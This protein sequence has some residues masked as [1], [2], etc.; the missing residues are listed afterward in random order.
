MSVPK[1]QPRQRRDRT[2]QATRTRL[3][4]AAE[5]VFRRDGYHGAELREIARRASVTTGAVYWS[6]AN[7]ADLFLA[8]FD[9][10]LE[11]RIDEITAGAIEPGPTRRAARN[12]ADW[13]QRLERQR[14]W[15]IVLLEFRL[16]AARHP[17]LNREFRRRHRRLL[18]ASARTATANPKRE[19][20]KRAR[21]SAVGFMALGN[22]F[23]L[24][25]LTDPY[26]VTHEQYVDA[27]R[28]MSGGATRRPR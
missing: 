19:P 4:D 27:A 2:E 6:F 1:R 11:R 13:F 14:D 20:S 24:E 26:N 15:Q 3:L 9:R 17:Q 12:A 16:H 22:G 21:D 8:V 5:T 10:N 25:R 18:E 28:R 23:A 7:K